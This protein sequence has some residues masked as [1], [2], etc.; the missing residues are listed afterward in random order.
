[1][2]PQYLAVGGGTTTDE[3]SAVLD[4]NGNPI[5]AASG[6]GLFSDVG[7]I[8][9]LGSG[10]TADALAVIKGLNNPAAIATSFKQYTPAQIAAQ[11]AGA[12]NTGA[13]FSVTN[14]NQPWF[15]LLLAGVAIAVIAIV[16]AAVRPK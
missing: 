6:G 1:M 8:L 4:N 5:S 11:N 14:T 9:Q 3:N 2:D 12:L 13:Q 16:A 7:N 15:W 10:F